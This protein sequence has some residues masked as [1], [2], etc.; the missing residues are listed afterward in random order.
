MLYLI[1]RVVL[2]ELCL[3]LTTPLSP[4]ATTPFQSL[5]NTHTHTHHVCPLQ[6]MTPK[7]V[8]RVA[9]EAAIAQARKGGWRLCALCTT[10]C[11]L[12]HAACCPVYPAPKLAPHSVTMTQCSIYPPSP[13]LCLHRGRGPQGSCTG[14]HQWVSLWWRERQRTDEPPARCVPACGIAPCFI[15]GCRCGWVGGMCCL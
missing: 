11:E 10:R 5:K 3:P 1:S 13:V 15:H 6:Y 7:A 9:D 8:A 4:N 14:C 2:R 12:P